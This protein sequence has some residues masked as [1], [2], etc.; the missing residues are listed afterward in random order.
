MRGNGSTFGSHALTAV[1]TA[2]LGLGTWQIIPPQ[3][4]SAKSPSDAV[5]TGSTAPGSFANVI[6]AVQRPTMRFVPIKSPVQQ[7]VLFCTGPGNCSFIS[8]PR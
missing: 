5:V 1:L 6:E 8:A 4:V 2:A 7:S 3:D